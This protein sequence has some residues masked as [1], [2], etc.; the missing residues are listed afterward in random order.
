MVYYKYYIYVNGIID[1]YI[2]VISSTFIH[3]GVNYMWLDGQYLIKLSMVQ[4]TGLKKP[5]EN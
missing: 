4:F 3:E 1:G 2:V 5:D